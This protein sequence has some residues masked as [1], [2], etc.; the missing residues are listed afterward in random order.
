M[1]K[2]LSKELYNPPYIA[3]RIKMYAKLKKVSLKLLLIECNL[4]INTFSNMLHGRAIA[5]DSLAC[6]ADYL[7]CSVDFLLGRT[8]N[9]ILQRTKEFTK[10]KVNIEKISNEEGGTINFN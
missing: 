3:G 9:P 10:A 7:D 5:Y 4:G 2:E 6:I 8:E 1:N